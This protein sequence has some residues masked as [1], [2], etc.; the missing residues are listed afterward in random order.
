MKTTRLPKKLDRTTIYQSEWI[1]LYTDKVLMPSGKIIEKY[2][3][4]DFPQKS[5]VVL[6]VNSKNEICFI[7][8]L[9]Y[10]TQKIEWELPAGNIEKDET[11]TQAAKR[12][13]LEETGYQTKKLKL[14]YTFNPANSMSNQTVHAVLGFA[15]GKA[16]LPFD[17][18]E[19][20]NIHWL[21]IKKVYQ[22]I[23]LNK[24]TC[25]ISVIPLLLY[26]NNLHK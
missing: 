26:L 25:G 5:V 23:K 17:T 24:I 1:N 8:S 11:I 15:S 22:L 12:E 7:K 9:R 13:I 18:D 19:I 10:T 14:L 21:S 3:Q 2:H 20:K 6:M 4:L 16:P